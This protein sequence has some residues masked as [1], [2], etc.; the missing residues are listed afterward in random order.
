MS[1]LLHHYNTEPG[2]QQAINKCLSNN[3]INEIM[4]KLQS[5]CQEK[6]RERKDHIK[7]WGVPV[8]LSVR[9]KTFKKILFKKKKS[10]NTLKYTD[11]W[12]APELTHE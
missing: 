4:I 5:K 7:S 12:H 11:I 3:E 2:T 1:S 10:V 6:H 8:V 9:T